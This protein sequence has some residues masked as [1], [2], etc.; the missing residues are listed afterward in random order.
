MTVLHHCSILLLNSFILLKFCK[1]LNVRSKRKSSCGCQGQLS[2]TRKRGN[3]R[4]FPK[5]QHLRNASVSISYG[6][7]SACHCHSHIRGKH[8]LTNPLPSSTS[9]PGLRLSPRP[10]PPPPSPPPPR[11][12]NFTLSLGLCRDKAVLQLSFIR[13]GF[14]TEETKAFAFWKH[15]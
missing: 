12:F 6:R 8:C 10:R 3:Q 7:R 5:F 4:S 15:R 1:R 9:A 14:F 2:G 11:L 13:H